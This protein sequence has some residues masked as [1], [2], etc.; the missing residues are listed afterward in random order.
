[1]EII[2]IDTN[3]LK[4]INFDIE[5]SKIKHLIKLSNICGTKLTLSSLQVAEIRKHFKKDLIDNVVS[6]YKQII[7][8][9]W[10]G[11]WA[12]NEYDIN[13]FVD[14][15]LQELM[16]FIE[17]KFEILNEYNIFN[18]LNIIDLYENNKPPFNGKKN[19]EFKDALTISTLLSKYK[20]DKLIFI[21]KD[22][23]F[24]DCVNSLNLECFD[25]LDVIIN[26]LAEKS[27]DQPNGIVRLLIKNKKIIEQKLMKKYHGNEIY[28]ENFIDS[29]LYIEN[30]KIEKFG[31]IICLDVI[32]NRYF[33]NI[34]IDYILTIEGTASTENECIWDSEDEYYM[35]MESPQFIHKVENC[36]W[37]EVSVIY[38]NEDHEI[39]KINIEESNFLDFNSMKFDSI[40]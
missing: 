22:K 36:D 32:E 27:T 37:L 23:Q 11:K 40:Y 38:N 4:G 9:K 15:S 35:V 26:K 8:N 1:M 20:A 28:G 18:P 5:N 14:N 2:N 3:I 16:K 30:I 21:T 25:D 12:K 7:Q 33:F 6:K 29:D 13:K 34:W 10:F 17:D 39:E 31:E 24:K 19:D